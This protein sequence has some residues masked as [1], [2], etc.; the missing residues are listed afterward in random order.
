MDL[1]Q[2]TLK[3]HDKVMATDLDSCNIT[4]LTL[5]GGMSVDT[6]IHGMQLGGDALSHLV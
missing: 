6:S 5:T 4:C 3:D 1:D 2:Y